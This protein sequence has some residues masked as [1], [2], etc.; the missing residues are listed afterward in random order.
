MSASASSFK[1]LYKVP[2]FEITA[3]ASA[4]ILSLDGFTA[5]DVD[6]LIQRRHRRL[7]TRQPSAY[8]REDMN[9]LFVQYLRTGEEILASSPDKP[10]AQGVPVDLSP[11]LTDPILQDPASYTWGQLPVTVRFST[12][13]KF[14]DEPFILITD[15]GWAPIWIGNS[16]DESAR[17]TA[18]TARFCSSRNCF[19]RHAKPSR[20]PS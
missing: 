11:I 7:I 19:S 9:E 18:P 20:S 14:A 10:V 1:R 3:T 13:M 5:D 15:P 4:Y 6:L 8:Q 16:A 17:S 2:V 12:M